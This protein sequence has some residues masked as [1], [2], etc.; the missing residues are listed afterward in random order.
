M[1]GRMLTEPQA[2]LLCDAVRCEIARQIEEGRA[3]RARVAAAVLQLPAVAALFR[4]DLLGWFVARAVEHVTEQRERLPTWL[5]DVLAG[6]DGKPAPAAVLS[7]TSV[8]HEAAEKCC[9]TT[10]FGAAAS[11]YTHPHPHGLPSGAPSRP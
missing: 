5:D 9:D 8:R 2:I 6:L 10:A 1:R 7:G 3:T 4:P 11:G